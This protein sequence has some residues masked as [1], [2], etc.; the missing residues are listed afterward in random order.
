M[1][2]PHMSNVSDSALRRGESGKNITQ[3]NNLSHLKNMK[4]MI[5]VVAQAPNEKQPNSNGKKLWIR[6]LYFLFINFSWFFL[7]PDMK[8]VYFIK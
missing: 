2:S 3:A 1:P 6:N 8:N 4:T 5:V 7:V